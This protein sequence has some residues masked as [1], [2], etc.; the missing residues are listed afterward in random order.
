MCICGYAQE[1]RTNNVFDGDSLL[2]PRNVNEM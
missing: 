2:P 1:K